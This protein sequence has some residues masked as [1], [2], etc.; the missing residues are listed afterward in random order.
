VNGKQGKNCMR[1]NFSNVSPSLIE[2]GIARLARVVNRRI[3]IM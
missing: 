1:L 3:R 2:D